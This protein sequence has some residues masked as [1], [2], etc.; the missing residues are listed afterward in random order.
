[1]RKMFTQLLVRYIAT[2]P[3]FTSYPK[4]DDKEGC[5]KA[6][7]DEHKSFKKMDVYETY[8]GDLNNIRPIPIKVI[9]NQKVD[10]QGNILKH[11]V[12]FF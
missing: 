9:L 2:N 7:L 1:M 6:I 4:G 10:F 8:T 11:K 12:R 3:Y 5:I